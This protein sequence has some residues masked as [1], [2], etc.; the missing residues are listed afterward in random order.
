MS[1]PEA[2]PAR[3]TE[4]L[5]SVSA[6]LNDQSDWWIIGSTAVALHGA[7]SIAVGDV[8]LLTTIDNAPRLAGELGIDMMPGTASELFRSD[9]FGRWRD[10]PLT[11]EVMAGLHV[12]SRGGWNSVLPAT[13]EQID[14]Q[15]VA[16]FVPSREELNQML[17][18]FDRPKDRER[19]R[20]L[21]A[22]M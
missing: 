19:A 2:L 7:G 11:V 12:R 8:D 6:V 13:R 15:G 5:L 17:L 16:L 21:S 18:S 14:V 20:L 4:T 3:L 1:C 10:P 9:L 22:V